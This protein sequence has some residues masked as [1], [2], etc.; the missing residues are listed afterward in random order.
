MISSTFDAGCPGLYLPRACSTAECER[1][2]HYTGSAYAKRVGNHCSTLKRGAEL[3]TCY[4][5]SLMGTQLTLPVCSSTIK[6]LMQRVILPWTNTAF[7]YWTAIEGLMMSKIHTK[8]SSQCSGRGTPAS[9]CQTAY[10]ENGGIDTTRTSGTSAHG[11]SQI[12]SLRYMANRPASAIGG[13]K[14]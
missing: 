3:R 5:R 7:R 4:S 9:G 12:R 2:T 1:Y 8:R 10:W 14:P 13:T 11:I 6:P